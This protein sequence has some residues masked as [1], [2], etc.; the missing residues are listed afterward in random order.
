MVSKIKPSLVS[1]SGDHTLTYFDKTHRYYFNDKPVKSITGLGGAYPKAQQLIDWQIKQGKVQ[2]TAFMN[3]ASKIGTLVHEYIYH[4]RN[5][6]HEALTKLKA[7]V[8]KHKSK[9][10]IM[11]GINAAQDWN[12]WSENK[13]EKAEIICCS[14][15]LRVAGKFDELAFK[16][17]G[18]KGVVD[19][20]TSG[21]IYITHFQQA[22]G[23]RRLILDWFKLTTDWLEVVRFDK[24]SGDFHVA[25]IDGRG[26]WYDGE[27][28]IED[29]FML[30]DMDDQFLRNVG[31]SKYMRK[32]ENFWKEVR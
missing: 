32:Y 30:A 4:L 23:Y 29:N 8:D 19:Y 24:E 28:K 22:A 18:T 9:T 11:H 5:N 7:Q 25:T 13:L 16:N 21:G 27:L 12:K 26:L 6:D 10:A 2:A 15:L 20:K 17:D 14:P 1:Y 31:T 3:K